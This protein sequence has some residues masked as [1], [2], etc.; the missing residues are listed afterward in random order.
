MFTIFLIIAALA[1]AVLAWRDLRFSLILMVALLPTY[2]VR[3]SIGPIPLTLLEVFLL[4]ALIAWIAH[5][6]HPD[7][8]RLRAAGGVLESPLPVGPMILFLAAASFGVVVAEDT[9]SAL[10]IWKAYFI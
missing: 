2:L 10:G 6:I 7:E 1:F 9:L 5:T 3:F 4:I 8:K